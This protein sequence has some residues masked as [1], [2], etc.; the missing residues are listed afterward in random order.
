MLVTMLL[1]ATILAGTPHIEPRSA[2]AGAV[3]DRDKDEK[4]PSE[5]ERATPTEVTPIV[6]RHAIK[7]GGKEL[8]YTATAGLLPIVNEA[9][10]TEA[11][12]F[13]IAYMAGTPS[14]DRRRPLLFLFNGGPGASSVWLHLGTA[15]P[16]R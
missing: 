16:R 3:A 7:A 5:K 13:Y 10:E 6:T 4:R 15:G 8:R 1:I 14:P 2:D 12:I 9:G 11:Q